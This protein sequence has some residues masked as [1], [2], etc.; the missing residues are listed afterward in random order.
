MRVPFW[1]LLGLFISILIMD[2]T[3]VWMVRNKLI[4]A[5]EHSLDAAMI[6]GLDPND[7][8]GGKLILNEDKAYAAAKSLLQKNLR[9]DDNL[10]S[11]FFKHTELNVTI[12]PDDR[13]PKFTV[14]V[15]TVVTANLPK[16]I[17]QAGIPVTIH[18]VQY[19]ISKYR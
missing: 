17:G 9:L 6:E 13:K 16:I 2:I 19:H 12:V 14:D 5:V 8:A 1:M 15:K 7:A 18:K 4:T 11:N 10:E 3:S